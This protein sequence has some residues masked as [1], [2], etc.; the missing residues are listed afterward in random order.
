MII[1][2]IE[3]PYITG[4]GICLAMFFVSSSHHITLP[5]GW[6]EL[7]GVGLVEEGVVGVEVGVSH[8]LGVG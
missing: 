7:V 8:Y 1:K 4:W 5:G 6:V 2:I 3:W